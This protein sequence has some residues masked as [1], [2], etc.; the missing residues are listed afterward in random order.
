[1][2]ELEA[3]PANRVMF[4]KQRIEK[5]KAT[6][7]AASW[8]EWAETWVPQWKDLK[9]LESVKV[10]AWY[11]FLHY[12]M[13]TMTN[14][15]S[16]R[17]T[18]LSW[19]STDAVVKKL[20]RDKGR[21]LTIKEIAEESE[22]RPFELTNVDG[23]VSNIINNPDNNGNRYFQDEVNA[24]RFDTLNVEQQYGDEDMQALMGTYPEGKQLEKLKQE[25]LHKMQ[26]EILD[27]I[28]K[29]RDYL[30]MAMPQPEHAVLDDDSISQ[31]Q[32]DREKRKMNNA[33]FKSA[34]MRANVHDL[35][36]TRVRMPK[37]F[38]GN[39]AVI[40]EVAQ[41]FE[42]GEI[43][44]IKHLSK[45]FREKV[46]IA[47]KRKAKT[48]NKT[49]KL[50]KGQWV[51]LKQVP[52]DATQEQAD[53]IINNWNALSDT[54]WC[55]SRGMEST[56]AY[57]GPMWIYQ[58]GFG[59]KAES[60]LAIRFNGDI[61]TGYV[62]EIQSQANDG[63][64]PAEY[65]PPVKEFSKKVE[66]GQD[67]KETIDNAEVEANGIALAESL[68]PTGA[69]WVRA[70]APKIPHTEYK[71]KADILELGDGT[72]ALRPLGEDRWRDIRGLLDEAREA[73]PEDEAKKIFC[74][75]R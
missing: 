36:P 37:P 8:I 69:E 17:N 18:L 64:I 4:S 22:S 50:G 3:L 16:A 72:Y 41:M 59:E 58:E 29:N 57:E 75:H 6:G 65:L 49:V 19:S 63:T 67:A 52:E 21:K 56:Y 48:F 60:K 61:E 25:F 53:E 47:E 46:E 66:L 40:A 26:K 62:E 31:A 45:V 51:E 55:T 7:G 73:N 24:W 43:T 44:G 12:T 23:Y 11:D 5:Y 9:T 38:S 13:G 32:K 39:G 71:V 33:F 10:A 30:E 28:T 68:A 74:N 27:V 70:K 1:M 15:Y 34:I 35:G 42:N 2:S 14:E 54:E 20:E